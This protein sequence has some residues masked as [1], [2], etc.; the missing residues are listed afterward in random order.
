VRTFSSSIGGKIKYLESLPQRSLRKF[1]LLSQG[2]LQCFNLAVSLVEGKAGIEIGGPTDVFQGG[3]TTLRSYG[4]S[5]P[6][7][8]YDRVGSLDNCNFSSE[9]LWS[10][11]QKAYHFSPRKAPGK[12]II[13]E[14]SAISCVIDGTYDFVLSS[15][16]LEHFANPVKA[17][18]EWKRISRPGGALILVLPHYRRSFDHRR[19]PTPV[20]HMI[21]DY[22]K[23]VG[24]DD[25][26]HIPEVLQLHDLEMDGTLRTHTLDEL[27]TRSVSNA[28]NRILHHH[29]F[30]EKNSVELL[31]HAGLDVLAVEQALPYH[32][33]I[34]SRWK[35]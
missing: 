28:S 13:A 9:T 5:T 15:H 8:I 1:R 32:I 17:L 31:T 6:L 22:T 29:V 34:F 23:N 26:T 24:E 16:N 30:D 27:R 4:W 14:G 18:M 11:H 21:E 3:H 25:T 7:P 33:F 19:T 20:S 12:N 2:R 10:T 35:V